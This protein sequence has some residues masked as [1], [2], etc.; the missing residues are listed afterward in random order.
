MAS[1]RRA[2]TVTPALYGRFRPRFAGQTRIHAQLEA[3][4]GHDVRLID[5][6]VQR[7]QKVEDGPEQDRVPIDEDLGVMDPMSWRQV[8]RAGRG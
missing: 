6:D 7:P 5:R 4:R 2:A 1:S 8:V 3:V